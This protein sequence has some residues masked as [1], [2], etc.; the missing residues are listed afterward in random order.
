[1][2]WQHHTT[3]VLFVSENKKPLR[4]QLL[5]SLCEWVVALEPHVSLVLENDMNAAMKTE[6]LQ[7]IS[8]QRFDEDM[9]DQDES[10]SDVSE[11]GH[12]SGSHSE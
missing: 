10:D 7:Y 8:R 5:K 4:M 6:L 1:M 11:D 12:S 9:G 3:N 2:Y